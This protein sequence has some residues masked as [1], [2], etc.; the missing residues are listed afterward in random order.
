MSDIMTLTLLTGLLEDLRPLLARGAHPVGD[1][2]ADALEDAARRPHVAPEGAVAVPDRRL[3]DREAGGGQR[4]VVHWEQDP[5]VAWID[6]EQMIN[7]F[8]GKA[9]FA[10]QGAGWCQLSP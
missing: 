6:F 1:H 8:R 3:D 5:G 9:P 4:E 2:G 7:T 10:A